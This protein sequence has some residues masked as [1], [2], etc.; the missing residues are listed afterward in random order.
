MP[1]TPAHT[2]TEAA[3]RGRGR[4]RVIDA[5]RVAETAIRLWRERGYRATG[6]KDIAD[7]TGVS[8]RTLMRHFG[9]RADIPWTGVDAATR[10]LATSLAALPDDVPTGEAIRRAVVDSV[11]HSEQVLRAAPD[12]LAVV[13]HE[14][15]L[16][17]AAPRA[18]A[19]WIGAIAEFIAD[20]N[21][22]AP[23][24]ICHALATAY[25]AA[26]FAALADWAADGAG[27]NPDRAVDRM[28]RWLDVHAPAA[29]DD[30]EPRP[31]VTAA[32]DTRRQE[33]L[34]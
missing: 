1:R 16:L 32:A 19:P 22:S 34:P 21:P 33:D 13:A 12:W 7:A 24:A 4:P 25:Q 27:E 26:A 29:D 10:R 15:D 11:T 6:W 17:V 14:P 3:A 20:R 18:Y 5:D 2:D 23:P 30:P 9:S 28:L 31:G 8:V